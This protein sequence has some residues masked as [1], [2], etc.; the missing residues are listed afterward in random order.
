MSNLQN[1]YC[2]VLLVVL[3]LFCVMAC[4]EKIEHPE[5]LYGSKQVHRALTFGPGTHSELIVYKNVNGWVD[6]QEPNWTSCQS[7]GLRYSKMIDEYEHLKNGQVKIYLFFDKTWI[8][9]FIEFD[10]PKGTVFQITEW[11]DHSNY[12]AI[13]IQNFVSIICQGRKV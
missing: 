4:S 11:D 8:S 7:L 12:D 5:P 1:N 3:V 10:N 13:D 9:S 2:G 6:G